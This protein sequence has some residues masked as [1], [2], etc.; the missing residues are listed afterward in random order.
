MF[1]VYKQHVQ[2]VTDKI[3]KLK[4]M[5][6][7]SNPNGSIYIVKLKCFY[8]SGAKEECAEGFC[9]CGWN[10]AC[11]P[12]HHVHQDGRGRVHAPLSPASRPHTHLQGS[13]LLPHTGRGL[14]AT[15]T[16]PG[17]DTVSAPPP[18]RNEQL[19]SSGQPHQ[20]HVIHV[21]EPFSF[22]KHTQGNLVIYSLLLLTLLNKLKISGFLKKTKISH[23][24]F[25]I[26]KA[27]LFRKQ[28]PV[29]VTVRY[30]FSDC[31]HA[32]SDCMF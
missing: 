15:K 22:Y 26:T 24:K 10:A 23:I 5:Y 29:L 27:T 8:D 19:H 21:S 3:D 11:Q 2:T 20:A 16:Q 17:T 12:L 30:K 31:I 28:V 4:K 6:F 13:R 14:L 18:R 32:H 1:V 25:I 7:L 9:E